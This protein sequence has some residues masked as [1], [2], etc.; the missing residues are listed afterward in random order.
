DRALIGVSRGGA[1]GVDIEVV[2]A[3][4]PYEVASM[5]FAPSERQM[6]EAAPERAE[7]FYRLWVRK[8][9]LA[10][11]IGRGLSLNL[12]D[13][14]VHDGLDIPVSRPTLPSHVADGMP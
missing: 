5:T 6:L 9:A 4:P 7:L 13:I 12:R 2:S 10:K 14:A 3:T 11:A 1:I 8:E